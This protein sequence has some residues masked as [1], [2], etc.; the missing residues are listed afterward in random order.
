MTGSPHTHIRRTPQNKP[1]FAGL[2]RYNRREI[3]THVV[4]QDGDGW[5]IPLDSI[6]ISPTGIFVR[7]DFL[8]E[9]GEEHTLIF[10]IEGRG[11]FRML[12]RVARVERPD[13][14]D[15]FAGAEMRPGMGY[16]F[17]ETKEKTWHDLC[18]VV[19]GA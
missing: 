3:A 1:A 10:Q 6:D 8:F 4:V 5:E 17:V 11:I 18:S 14:D 12:A 15:A 19:A 13:E 16:E 2:R 7:S 9:I